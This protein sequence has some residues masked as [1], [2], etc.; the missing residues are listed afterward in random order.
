M[1]VILVL[2]TF[3]TFILVDTILSRRKA[4]QASE[5]SASDPIGELQQAPLPAAHGEYIEGFRTP[6]TVR[7]HPGHGWALRERRNVIRVGLDEFAAKLAGSIERIELPKAGHWVRQGQKAIAV[8][9]NG[10]KAELVSPVE[11]EVAEVNPDVMA[12]P[13]LLRKDPYGRGWLMT[14]F[15]PDEE[16]TL[17]NLMPAQLVAGWMRETVARFYA[18]QPQLAGRVAADGGLPVDDLCSAIPGSDWRTLTEEFFL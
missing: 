17:R 2:V 9:R 14:V 13:S 10:E 3:L 1:T 8:F 15:A 7:Y 6:A 11:G 5:V 4:R 16:T 12:D 18:V